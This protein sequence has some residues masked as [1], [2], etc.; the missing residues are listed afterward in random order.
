MDIRS[1]ILV[2]FLYSS[3]SGGYRRLHEILKL[4]KLQGIG[5]VVITDSQSCRNAFRIFPRFIKIL[6]NYKVYKI[7]S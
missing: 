5:Y 1:I 2:K 4:G 7:D 6:R 3:L